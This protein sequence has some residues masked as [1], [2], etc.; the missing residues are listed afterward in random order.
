MPGASD[1]GRANWRKSTRSNGQGACVEVAT[2]GRTFGLR[3]SK[4]PTGPVLE[5][6]TGDWAAFL[7]G[8]KG[9]QFDRG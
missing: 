8:A 7:R 4:D 5:V 9:C 3:D 6:G 1:I 2:F